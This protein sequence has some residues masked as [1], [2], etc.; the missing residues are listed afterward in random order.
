M[1]QN[2]HF[3]SD[4]EVRYT[5]VVYEEVLNPCLFIADVEE[6][7]VSANLVPLKSLIQGSACQVLKKTDLAV[8]VRVI[9][10]KFKQRRWL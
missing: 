2:D 4:Y 8:K 1:L 3:D 5:I 6:C 10:T 7:Q 9:V